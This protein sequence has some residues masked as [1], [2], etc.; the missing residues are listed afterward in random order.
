MKAVALALMKRL[1]VSVAILLLLIGYGFS[2][3]Y[4]VGRSDFA[5]ACVTLIIAWPWALPQIF[6]VVCIVWFIVQCLRK[7]R[8]KRLA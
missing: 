3:T 7:F 5:A 6:I 1:L 4:A 2:Y 8:R